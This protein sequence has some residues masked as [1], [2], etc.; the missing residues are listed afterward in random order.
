LPAGSP[1]VC[2][3]STPFAYVRR[4]DL[5]PTLAW[6]ERGSTPQPEARTGTPVGRPIL[7]PCGGSRVE[8]GGGAVTHERNANAPGLSCGGVSK[9]KSYVPGSGSTAPTTGS[10][11]SNPWY[12]S[13]LAGIP[14]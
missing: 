7:S 6:S 4:P 8:G 2:S 14:V 13:R 9:T 10:A 3:R 11:R 5:P 1:L 12:G